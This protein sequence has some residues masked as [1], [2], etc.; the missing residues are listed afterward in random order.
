MSLEL[1]DGRL[2]EVVVAGPEDG[3]LLIMNHTA[4]IED[5]LLGLG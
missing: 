3:E 2:L 4:G 5:D 1:A